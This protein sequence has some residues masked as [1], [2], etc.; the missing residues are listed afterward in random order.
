MNR[1][2]QRANQYHPI[3]RGLHEVYNRVVDFGSDLISG[4]PTLVEDLDLND[5]LLAHSPIPVME[6]LARGA[7]YS[8]RGPKGPHISVR[9]RE[10]GLPGILAHEIGH[11]RAEARGGLQRALQGRVAH[12]LYRAAPWTGLLSGLADGDDENVGINAAL[13]AGVSLPYVAAEANATRLG[14]QEMARHGATPAQMSAARRRLLKAWGTYAIT[15]IAAA[16]SVPAAHWLRNK[17][18]KA[19][20]HFK[21]APGAAP[22]AESGAQPPAVKTAY[23]QGSYDALGQLG[24]L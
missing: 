2:T 7:Y 19:Y 22:H 4:S 11:A 20:D 21:G 5:R 13:S 18:I 16:A 24:L 9:S 17:A 14:L 6:D 23:A 3:H 15:P 12:G 1:F 10:F 8:P